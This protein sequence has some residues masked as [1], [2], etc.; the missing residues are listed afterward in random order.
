MKKYLITVFSWIAVYFIY[1]LFKTPYTIDRFITSVI[2][3]TIFYFVSV[4]NRDKFIAYLTKIYF[5]K[6]KV[7]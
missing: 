6:N 1:S 3:G 2:V 4:K 7:N 5:G